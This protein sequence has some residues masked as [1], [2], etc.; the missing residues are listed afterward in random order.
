MEPNVKTDRQPM[1]QR[2]LPCG[3]IVTDYPGNVN[4]MMCDLHQ[5]EHF[6]LVGLPVS[7]RRASIDPN[8]DLIGG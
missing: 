2:V 5:R 8:L 1:R 4:T 6:A 3:C 7:K